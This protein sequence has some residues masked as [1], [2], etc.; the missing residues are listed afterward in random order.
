[1]NAAERR[2]LRYLERVTMK[3][4]KYTEDDVGQCTA[5]GEW[6]SV[7]DSCCGAPVAFEGG[8]VTAEMIEEQ[9]DYDR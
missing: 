4:G 1:M 8:V 3:D 7:V 9:R 2:L 5:C 6:T